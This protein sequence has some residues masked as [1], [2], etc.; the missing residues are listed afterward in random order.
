MAATPAAAGSSGRKRAASAPA[1]TQ[2]EPSAVL[3]LRGPR[4]R[5]AAAPSDAQK[6]RRAGGGSAEE[7][8][9]E[10]GPH[11]SRGDLS[12]LSA[13]AD[14]LREELLHNGVSEDELVSRCLSFRD[15]RLPSFPVI[16]SGAWARLSPASLTAAVLPILRNGEV[17]PMD[18]LWNAVVKG[19]YH[20][21]KTR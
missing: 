7:P 19:S 5:G 8:R 14:T 16:K 9:D 17:P 10:R 13:L 1:P 6:R 11:I 18:G 4:E 20:F 2:L 21:E 3:S 12:R 15:G